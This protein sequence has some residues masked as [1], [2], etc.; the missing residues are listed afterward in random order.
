MLVTF[1]L[2]FTALELNAYTQKSATWDEPIHLTAGYAALAQHDYR[3]DPSHPPFLRMWA[4]LPLLAVESL[5]AD[6]GVIDRTPIPS[7]LEGTGAPYHFSRQFLYSRGDADRLLYAAR[8]MVV[9]L[10]I[11]GGILVFCWANEWLGFLPAVCAL[12]LY[13]VEPN[14]SAHASLVTTDFGLTCFMFGTIYFLWRTSRG[15]TTFNVATLAMFFALAVVTKFSAVLLGP[16]VLA[17]LA[18]SVA[19]RSAITPKA[20]VGI[21]GLLGATAFVAIWAICGFQ[22]APSESGTWLLHLQDIAPVRQAVPNVAKVV[23]WIDARQLLP[24]IFTQGFL[25]CLATLQEQ[26]AFLAGQYSNV[27]W[28]YYFP[29]A[30][31][32]KTP[33]ALL[34]LLLAGVLLCVRRPRE[35]GSANEAFVVLPI[36]VYLG[37]AM[38]SAFNIGVRHI[39]PIYPFVILIA[40]AAGRKL[41]VAHRTWNRIALATLTTLA[42]AEFGG[43]WPHTLTFFNQLVGGPP[44]GFKYLADSNLDWGQ[45]LKGLGQWMNRNGVDHVN[46]AYFGQADPVYY[47]ISSTPLPVGFDEKPTTKPELPGYVAIGATVLSGVYLEPVWQLFYRPFHDRQPVADIGNS[48]RVYWVDEWPTDTHQTGIV[49][50]PSEVDTHRVLADTLLLTQEWYELAA[51]HYQLHLQHRPKSRP[52]RGGA[53]TNLAIALMGTGRSDEAIQ[54]FRRA[55][56]V[57]PTNGGMQ[58]NLANALADHGEI[59]EAA[60]YARRAVALQPDDPAAFDLLGKVLARQGKL[61]EAVDAFERSLNVDP[62]Y[63]DAR[64]HLTRIREMRRRSR[65]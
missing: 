60:V 24:N 23:G 5:R 43:V 54:A 29:V 17:L 49:P 33:I 46:L 48:I 14:L 31:L 32:I 18:L 38:A 40:A 6:T 52:N 12:I 3:V 4:A 16:I 57:N 41:L 44:N 26:S 61:D 64:D 21:I 56:T 19:W 51:R 1:A 34:A 42:I 8:F 2:A 62:T 63:A 39:L 28:W 37:F 45:G 35:L 7:W 36:V 10:G 11:V 47:H 25:F 58:R 53:L 50:T 13:T 20:A 30:F 15:A 65:P 22:Y 59:D 9:I 27:G 55:A